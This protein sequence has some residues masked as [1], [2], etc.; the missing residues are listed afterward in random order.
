MRLHISRTRS[1]GDSQHCVRPCFRELIGVASSALLRHV[2]LLESGCTHPHT[3]GLRGER[4]HHLAQPHTATYPLGTPIRVFFPHHTPNADAWSE[5]ELTPP[6]RPR[7][8][9]RSFEYVCSVR[10][11][12]ATVGP[13]PIT[14]SNPTRVNAAAEGPADM[15]LSL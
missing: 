2:R 5:G 12:L 8:H 13:P 7:N 4:P 3:L 1:G 11:P 6:M 9:V 15:D 14:R 10:K